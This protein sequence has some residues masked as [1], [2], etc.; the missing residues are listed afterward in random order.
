MLKSDLIV[1]QIGLQNQISDF[2]RMSDVR[3][4][5]RSDKLKSACL[6]GRRCLRSQIVELFSQDW[7]NA[8]G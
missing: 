8:L 6:G 5:Q 2:L 1:D 4:S 3:F 7:L